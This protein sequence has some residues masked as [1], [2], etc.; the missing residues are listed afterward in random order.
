MASSPMPLAKSD[1]ELLRT[2]LLLRNPQV[3][4]AN[5]PDTT[6]Y[7]LSHSAAQPQIRLQ[8]SRPDVKVAKALDATAARLFHE[9]LR[10]CC[11]IAAAPFSRCHRPASICRPGSD[12][13]PAAVS[14]SR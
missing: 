7:E 14:A 11:L 2:R 13:N 12:G 4:A 1:R 10:L 8:H 5:L 9:R 3:A 6:D